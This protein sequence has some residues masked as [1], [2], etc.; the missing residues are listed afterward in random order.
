MNDILSSMF[1]NNHPFFGNNM[2]RTFFQQ[3]PNFFSF[4]TNMVPEH[5]KYNISQDIYNQIISQYG[6]Y[7]GSRKDTKIEI[8]LKDTKFK[9]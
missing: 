2:Q 6:R 7:N 4:S 8:N 1:G 3:G 5:Q 9:K